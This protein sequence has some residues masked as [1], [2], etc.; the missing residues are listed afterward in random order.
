MEATLVLDGRSDSG[1]SPLIM[2]NERLADPLDDFTKAIA[3]ISKKRGKTEADHEE[4]GRLE[5][6]GGLYT[7]PVLNYPLTGGKVDIG[8]PAWN[9]IR[10]LQDGGKRHKRGADVPRGIYPCQ[11]FAV[12]EF[13]A[14]GQTPAQLWKGGEHH[15]RKSVGVQK[16]KTMR[17]RPY[18]TDWQLKLPI[19][20][21][22]N[23]FDIHA[24]E[25]IWR[26]AGKYAGLGDMRPIYGRFAGTIE[27]SEEA[28]KAAEKAAQGEPELAAA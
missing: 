15:L 18:F 28:L 4:I 16:A 9:I 21:D 27:V 6:L 25:N 19:E 7:D 13:E 10:C 14:V 17:T 26:E 24:L 11:E 2:H 20:V 12:L 3:K 22:M 5:F 23:I 1:G 8:I